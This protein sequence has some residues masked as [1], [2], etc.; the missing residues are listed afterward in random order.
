M[1]WRKTIFR[2]S[3]LPAIV[4]QGLDNYLWTVGF[5]ELSSLKVLFEVIIVVSVDKQL[6]NQ[7]IAR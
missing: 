4:A 5:A 7:R 2:S 1:I 6:S 3:Y